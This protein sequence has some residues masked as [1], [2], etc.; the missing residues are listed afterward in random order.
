[1]HPFNSCLIHCA[2]STRNR[3]SFSQRQKNTELLPGSLEVSRCDTA[4]RAVAAM[5]R[6]FGK[7]RYLGGITS[8]PGCV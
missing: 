6:W 4:R 3:A 2:W 7:H 8:R 1:M 5:G